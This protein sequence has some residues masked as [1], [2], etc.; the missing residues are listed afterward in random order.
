MQ[1]QGGM[2]ISSRWQGDLRP[3]SCVPAEEGWCVLGLQEPPASWG[4]G[5]V[6]GWVSRNLVP[7]RGRAAVFPGN[8]GGGVGWKERR[9]PLSTH[10]SWGP[11]C[12]TSLKLP[13]GSLGL[14]RED[15]GRAGASFWPARQSLCRHRARLACA[16]ELWAVGRMS[17][18]S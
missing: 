5:W 9:C 10:S 6:G 17:N 14:W 7:G 4:E 11:P 16:A 2:E 15:P 1:W 13:Q 18:E 12:L 3:E 8:C